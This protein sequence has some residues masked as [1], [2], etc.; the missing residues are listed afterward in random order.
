MPKPDTGHAATA[1]DPL[2]EDIGVSGYFIKCLKNYA[3]FKGRARRKEFA[4]VGWGVI[5]FIL[6]LNIASKLAHLVLAETRWIW[7]LL[8]IA[9]T[10]MPPHAA[11]FV[12][13]MHDIGKSAWNILWAAA[14]S[15]C[16]ALW[17]YSPIIVFAALAIFAY[18]FILLCRKGKVGENKYGSDPLA[19]TPHIPGQ[20][21]S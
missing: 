6:A 10:L 16:S 3:N 1:F 12:R 2:F 14:F 19:V 11:V 20:E 13:R 17:E 21:L 18:L 7:V 8:F 15:L 9:L 5:L 4:V